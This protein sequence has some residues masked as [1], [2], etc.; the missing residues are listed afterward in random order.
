M[1]LWDTFRGTVTVRQFDCT[2]TVP[3]ACVV[4][5]EAPGSP[6]FDAVT[7]TGPRETS[8]SIVTCEVWSVVT[9]YHDLPPSSPLMLP[10]STLQPL[11]NTLPG[12]LPHTR[13]D[14]AP[15]WQYHNIPPSKENLSAAPSPPQVP[16]L[17]GNWS[18]WTRYI[19]QFGQWMSYC[20]K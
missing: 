12:C 7:I 5:T 10:L 14:P 16:G 11:I 4:L 8:Q 13:P 19:T 6:W 2:L 20:R 1:S 3:Q 9:D 17:R 18:Q 15:S